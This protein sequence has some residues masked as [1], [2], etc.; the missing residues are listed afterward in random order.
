MSLSKLNPVEP[1]WY[2]PVCPVVWEGWYRE[3]SPYPDHGAITDHLYR[4]NPWP[5]WVEPPRS[6]RAREGL[7][8]ALSGMRTDISS[9]T[10]SGL[11]GY[12]FT[13]SPSGTERM[14]P[15]WRLGLA[16]TRVP[17]SPK[18]NVY[19]GSLVSGH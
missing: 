3:V 5:L 12:R 7:E 8:S 18:I 9:D 6:R 10:L 1:P 14:N 11:F 16:K 17:P 15:R 13:I 19:I 4:T 2:G